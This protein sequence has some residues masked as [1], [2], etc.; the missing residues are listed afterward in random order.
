MFGDREV[1][2]ELSGLVPLTLEG[3][4][5]RGNLVVFLWLIKVLCTFTVEWCMPHVSCK[6][7]HMQQSW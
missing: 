5:A 3:T 1:A 6:E 7:K 2:L 4:Y